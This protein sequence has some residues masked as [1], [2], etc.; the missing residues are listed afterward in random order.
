MH[1]LILGASGRTGGLLLNEALSKNHTITALAR[2]PASITPQSGL[3]V[4]QGS[5]LSPSDLRSAF[6]AKKVDAILITLSS[7]RASDSPFA[8]STSPANFLENCISITLQVM[9]EFDVNRIVYMSAFG[10]GNSNPNLWCPMRIMINNSTMGT[11]GFKDHSEAE[12]KLRESG[13]EWAVVRPAML[14]EGEGKKVLEMGEQG[15]GMGYLPGVTRES[16]VR[17]MVETAESVN[18][19]SRTVVICN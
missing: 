1:F 8:A 19:E 4:I 17:W 6:S 11:V 13:L 10:V 15:K 9:K 18:W 16:V 14:K 7:A 12:G 5:P 2:N 3:T